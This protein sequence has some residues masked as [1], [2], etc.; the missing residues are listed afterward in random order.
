MKEREPTRCL[1]MIMLLV[2]LS[3]SL[4][5]CSVLVERCFSRAIAIVDYHL[6]LIVRRVASF[7]SKSRTFRE[8]WRCALC[9]DDSAK[10]VLIFFAEDRRLGTF[11]RSLLRLVL[12]EFLVGEVFHHLGSV[13]FAL[14]RGE[15]G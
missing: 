12:L 2:L 3:F 11:F 13:G 8:R 14:S 5:F 10:E 6:R 15:S 9:R 4:V 1:L 7:G